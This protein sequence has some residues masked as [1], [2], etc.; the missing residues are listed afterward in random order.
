MNK[1]RY[2]DPK[3]HDRMID[4]GALYSPFLISVIPILEMI[5][6]LAKVRINNARDRLKILYSKFE[7]HLVYETCNFIIRNIPD[8]AIIRDTGLTENIKYTH[9]RDT[10]NQFGTFTNLQIVR[11]T[12]YV[13]FT[14]ET[15]C[16]MTHSLLNNMQMGDNIITTQILS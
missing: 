12:V 16:T 1:V 11:G 3:T 4:L 13:K 2:L 14:S 10:L 15:S 6:A 5:A 7:K 9:I 8:K